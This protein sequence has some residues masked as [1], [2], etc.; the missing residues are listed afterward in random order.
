MTKHFR[1][2]FF[3]INANVGVQHVVHKTSLAVGVSERESP[4]K[5]QA[6]KDNGEDIE[7]D[8]VL[9]FIKPFRKMDDDEVQCLCCVSVSRGGVE[10]AISASPRKTKQVANLIR[11]NEVIYQAGKSGT[12]HTVSAL[13][14]DAA[15]S[16]RDDDL[17]KAATRLYSITEIIEDN[18]MAQ[19]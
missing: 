8:T 13:T 6:R 18:R 14:D 17:A 19:F 12:V 10:V 5:I 3:C 2:V 1:L 16:G 11:E 4:E 9:H 15:S 7:R